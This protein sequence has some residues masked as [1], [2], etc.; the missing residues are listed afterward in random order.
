M[1][2]IDCLIDTHPMANEMNSV[3]AH[4]NGTT[5]AVVGMKTAVIK[6]EADAATRVCNDVNR[7]FY[8]LIHS[9]ISQK[10]AKLHSEVDSHLMKL[11]QLRKQLLAI[12]GRMERDYGM[13]SQRYIKLFNG[14]NKNLQQRIFELDKPTV[15]FAVSDT[16]MIT[17]RI[18]AL[19]ASVPVS[20]MESL[21]MSQKILIS[22][23]K[24]RGLH[25][26]DSMSRF[27]E[28]M[29][30]QQRL[31]NRVLLDK[32]MDSLGAELMIPVLVSESCF[33]QMGHV[34]ME[35]VINSSFLPAHIRTRIKNEVIVQA[36]S[37]QWESSVTS[38]ELISEFGKYLSSSGAS[39]RVKMMT[40]RLFKENSFQTVKSQQP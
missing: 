30:E 34:Q 26:I 32:K 28:E 18:K 10:I 20:Q 24:Y 17:N 38:P 22:N 23:I 40:D 16:S 29:N 4:I 3:S 9:Q 12:K 19:T 21:S 11:N 36:K 6:A 25:V 31:T 33:D 15:K 37:L 5:A 1:A 27:L 39:E 14:L 7:G 8:T 2:D 35:V 13:I